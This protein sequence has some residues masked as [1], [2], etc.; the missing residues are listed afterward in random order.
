MVLTRQGKLAQAMNIAEN[1]TEQWEK[2][3]YMNQSPDV[4][5]YSIELN[6]IYKL[7]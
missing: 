5:K 6:E 3:A 4:I 2:L 7:L 1:L